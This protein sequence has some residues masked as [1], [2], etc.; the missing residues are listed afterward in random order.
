[1]AISKDQIWAAAD[2]IQAEGKSP[3]LSAVRKAV[4]GGSY[5]TIQ[6]AMA[7]WKSRRAARASEAREPVPAAVSERL[8]QFGSDLWATALEAANARLDG[9]RKQFQE[10]LVQAEHARTEAASLADSLSEELDR[11]RARLLQLEAELETAQRQVNT[12]DSEL[13]VMTER[14]VAAEKGNAELRKAVDQAA[15]N[16]ML[17]R[18]RSGEISGRLAALEQLNAAL[19]QRIQPEPGR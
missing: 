9:E 13:R 3:T 5:S 18:E 10:S 16:A 17:A 4:G 8:A 19:L 2:A 11:A 14:L 6:D 1:M 15:E 12:L 7:E